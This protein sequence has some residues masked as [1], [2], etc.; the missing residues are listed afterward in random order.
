MV[1]IYILILNHF[2]QEYLENDLLIDFYN[3]KLDY[4]FPSPTAFGFPELP[5]KFELIDDTLDLEQL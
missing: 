2:F 1:L 4:K 5:E 3:V